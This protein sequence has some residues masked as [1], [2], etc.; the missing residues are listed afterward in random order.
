MTVDS[1]PS[2]PE[3]GDGRNAFGLTPDEAADCETFA[4]LFDKT[5]DALLAQ[6]SRKWTYATLEEFSGI[7]QNTWGSHKRGER[8]ITVP[9]FNW[10]AEIY[11]VRPQYRFRTWP[12]KKLVQVAPDEAIP[13]LGKELSKLSP[14]ERAQLVP[15]LL[16]A[17]NASKT[18]RA[19]VIA[20]IHEIMGT[21]APPVKAK[22]TA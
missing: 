15:A 16:L 2:S 7:A 13:L 20:A 17:I 11:G 1:P 18:K 22:R 8:A 5:N 14:Y 9:A 10:I 3:S 12:W 4:L 6:G 19:K 21:P